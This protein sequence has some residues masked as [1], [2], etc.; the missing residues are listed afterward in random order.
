MM[1]ELILRTMYVRLNIFTLIARLS[2]VSMLSV[3]K[4][5][6]HRKPLNVSVTLLV[7]KS[8]VVN[9]KM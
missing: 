9:G 8:L 1:L 3:R 5:V 6:N 7:R 2:S 4:T